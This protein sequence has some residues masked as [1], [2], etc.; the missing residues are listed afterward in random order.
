[1]ETLALARGVVGVEDVRWR[2]NGF[3][4]GIEKDE[5]VRG[6]GEVGSEEELAPTHGF[7]SIRC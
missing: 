3:L 4:E 7:C 1:M 6:G 5:L 2:E